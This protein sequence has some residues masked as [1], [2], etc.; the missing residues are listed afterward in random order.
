MLT[1]ITAPAADADRRQFEGRRAAGAADPLA[2]LRALAD[3]RRGCDAG[4]SPA[5]AAELSRRLDRAALALRPP[6][7]VARAAAEADR[8]R[9]SPLVRAWLGQVLRLPPSTV[10]LVLARSRWF[11]PPVEPARRRRAALARAL[12]DGL[13]RPGRPA[14]AT[15]R[16]FLLADPTLAAAGGPALERGLAAYDARDYLT[17]LHLLVP[18]L[19]A[20]LRAL[21]R[22]VPAR[23]GPGPGPGLDGLLRHDPLR[24]ALGDGL[25]GQLRAVLVTDGGLRHRLAHGRLP[26]AACTRRVAQDVVFCYLRLSRLTDSSA[27]GPAGDDAPAGAGPATTIGGTHV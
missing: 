24:R 26:P 9:A 14:A 7:V 19:E 23:G 12:L 1:T 4:R 11:L 25:V 22:R 3:A 21:L 17:A 10:L 8:P 20:V 18:R 27:A 2:A 16:A 5:R 15:L 6:G 13:D